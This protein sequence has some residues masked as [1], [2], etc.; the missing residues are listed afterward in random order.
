[1]IWII[2]RIEGAIPSKN[3]KI[4][5]LKDIN[6][7]LSPFFAFLIPPPPPP[8]PLLLS[9]TSENLIMVISELDSYSHISDGCQLK[10]QQELSNQEIA[11]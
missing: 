5:Q 2:D 7:A 8:L 3:G 9:G 4:Q 11:R 1:M 6:T 10:C